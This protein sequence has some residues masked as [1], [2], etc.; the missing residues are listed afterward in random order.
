MKR[1]DRTS[2]SYAFTEKELFVNVQKY[3]EEKLLAAERH[4]FVHPLCL[5]LD[6][7]GNAL[8][9]L[10]VNQYVNKEHSSNGNGAKYTANQNKIS[11]LKE[12]LSK[13]CEPLR[14]FYF[15]ANN[16]LLCNKL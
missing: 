4:P 1:T 5:C 6:T 8:Q 14:K 2:A 7:I 10:A 16:D 9:S 11:E 13:C 12:Y 3:V 15:N